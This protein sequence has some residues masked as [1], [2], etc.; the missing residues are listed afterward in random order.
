MIARATRALPG[1]VISLLLTSPAMAAATHANKDVHP[2]LDSRSLSSTHRSAPSGA[3][4]VSVSQQHLSAK[5]GATRHYPVAGHTRLGGRPHIHDAAPALS[6]N[7]AR[8]I[9]RRASVQ[10]GNGG[11]NN[12]TLID[13]GTLW[14]ESG[15]VA[16]W[17]QT[18]TASWYGGK[19]WQGHRTTSGEAY[20]EHALTAAHATLPLGTKVRVVSHNGARSVIVTIN[21]RPGTRSRIIDLSREA[22]KELGILDAGVAMVTLQPL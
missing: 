4:R 8:G 2:K 1:M 18:G 15:S 17:Q 5:V 16:T 14:R 12:G 6:M 21:D 3:S 13:D 7:T 11:A 9:I 20:D 22:A 19:R 10:G